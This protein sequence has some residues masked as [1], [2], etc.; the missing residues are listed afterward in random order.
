MRGL[1][2]VGDGPA[3][4]SAWRNAHHLLDRI[5]P[6]RKNRWDELMAE[7]CLRTRDSSSSPL[8]IRLSRISGRRQ[9]ANWFVMPGPPRAIEI[10]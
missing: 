8:D 2:A 5:S 3:L 1:A 7:F 9:R 4:R 6:S 10:R